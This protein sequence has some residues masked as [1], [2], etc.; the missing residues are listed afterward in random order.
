L[1]HARR[2]DYHYFQG[3]HRQCSGASFSI[4]CHHATT[5]AFSTALTPAAFALAA[6]ALAIS[7]FALLAFSTP[8]T[9]AVFLLSPLLGT[10]A[11]TVFIISVWVVRRHKSNLLVLI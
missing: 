3:L 11:F 2:C 5:A 10:E 1:H 8:A 7:A 9:P 6:F 4:C